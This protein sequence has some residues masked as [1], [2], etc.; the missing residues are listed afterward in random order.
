MHLTSEWTVE[1]T[2]GIHWL[3]PHGLTEWPSW[4]RPDKYEGA[5]GWREGCRQYTKRQKNEG[6]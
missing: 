5:V 3:E 2:A 4:K 1:N 6:H